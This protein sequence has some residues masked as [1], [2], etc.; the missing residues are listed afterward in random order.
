MVEA[1][2]ELRGSLGAVA[3]E[4]AALGG[5]VDEAGEI[6]AVLPAKM[7]EFFGVEVSGFLAQEGFEAPL[8]IGTVPGLEAVAP[9]G[10]PVVAERLQHG[11]IVHARHAGRVK[12]Y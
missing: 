7:E 4:A 2:D 9:S 11:C 1:V 6:V 10:N 8:E 3:H 12:S 5:P